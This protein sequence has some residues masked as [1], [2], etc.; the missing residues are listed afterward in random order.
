MHT[1]QASH[2]LKEKNHTCF[3]TWLDCLKYIYVLTLLKCVHYYATKA[4]V[5]FGSFTYYILSVS[6]EK[7]E[8]KC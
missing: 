8:K 1:V 3:S 2:M 5:C 6:I 4:T 7:T